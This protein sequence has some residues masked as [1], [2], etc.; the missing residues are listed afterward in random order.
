MAKSSVIMRR[1]LVWPK[2]ADTLDE[3][4]GEFVC[5]AGW[6]LGEAAP[7]LEWHRV[8]RWRWCDSF[9]LA[10]FHHRHQDARRLLYCHQ[11]NCKYFAHLNQNRAEFINWRPRP[12]PMCV[13]MFR[14][15][16]NWARVGRRPAGVLTK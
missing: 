3:V 1:Q 13:Q 7:S 16:F 8:T 15:R 11:L 2:L 9:H 6:A 4:G 12:R 5:L 14:E 10:S